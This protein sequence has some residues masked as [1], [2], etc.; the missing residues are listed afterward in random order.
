MFSL[1]SLIR[2]ILTILLRI[3]QYSQHTNLDEAEPNI[4]LPDGLVPLREEGGG[5]NA[6]QLALARQPLHEPEVLGLRGV[7][8]SK[9]ECVSSLD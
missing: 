2:I 1:N 8:C 4:V 5:G 9:G 3:D 6:L 7:S